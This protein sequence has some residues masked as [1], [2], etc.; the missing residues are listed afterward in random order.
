[1]ALRVGLVGLGKMGLSHL[2]IAGET[3]GMTIPAV[4]DS[5]SFLL[6][7]LNKYGSYEGYSDLSKM[8]DAERLDAVIVATPTRLHAPMV[9]EAIERGLH[10][11]C[12]KPFCLD[13]A[14]SEELSARATQ[15][16]LTTQVGYHNRYVGTFQEVGRLLE[17]GAI[18]EIT[19]IVA[20]AYGPVVLKPKGGTWRSKLNEGGGCLFD[21]AAHPLNLVNWW[22]GEPDSV[23][24][25]VMHSV[26]SREIEDEVYSTLTWAD[27]KTCH[28]SVNWSDESQR[29]MTTQIT[30]SGTEGKIYADRQECRVFLRDSA[31]PP[32]GYNPGW[33][34]RYTTSLTPPVGFYLRGEEYS[35]QL[36]DFVARATIGELDGNNFASALV[37]DRTLAAIIRDSRTSTDDVAEAAAS[38]HTVTND[39]LGRRRYSV[40]QRS[41]AAL[42]AAREGVRSGRSYLRERVGR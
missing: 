6:G 35:A 9:R 27:G 3:E 32:S 29:K 28:L 24:G 2:A 30:I 17:C 25:S 39:V 36:Q 31:N 15:K 33:N 18:G 8:L 4:C 11:F 7:V 13:V 16:A 34:V 14:D 5:N 22:F 38:R 41:S 26:F 42:G 12:E 20:E 40:K 10:V 23:R 19:H 37:T 1:M 21:Y